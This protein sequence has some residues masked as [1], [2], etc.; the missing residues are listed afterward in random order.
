MA[1]Y[2]SSFITSGGYRI[3]NIP[4][5]STRPGFGN[6]HNALYESGAAFWKENKESN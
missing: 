3:V 6:Y 2:P 5:N 1:T 4:L